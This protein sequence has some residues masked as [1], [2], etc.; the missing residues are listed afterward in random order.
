MKFLRK[1]LKFSSITTM[2]TSGFGDYHPDTDSWP[3]VNELILG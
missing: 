1:I 3:E 2:A